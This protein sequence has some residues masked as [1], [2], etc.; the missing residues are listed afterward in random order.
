MFIATKL[1]RMVTQPEKFSP[2]SHDK[3][4]PHRGDATLPSTTKLDRVVKI[5]FKEPI[6][7]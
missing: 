1:G 3:L 7:M 5:L 2:R 6:F 4:K